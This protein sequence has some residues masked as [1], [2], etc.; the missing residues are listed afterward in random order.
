M[1]IVSLCLPWDGSMFANIENKIKMRDWSVPVPMPVP[2]PAPKPTPHLCL[3]L[4][5]CLSPAISSPDF[6]IF[7]LV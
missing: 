1:V 7:I 4:C 3:L 5:L 6:L 2:V